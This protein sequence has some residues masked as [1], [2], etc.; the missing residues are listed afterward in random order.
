MNNIFV[1][2]KLIYL[3]TFFFSKW[4]KKYKD[5]CC[6]DK[7]RKIRDKWNPLI[8]SWILKCSF[9][10]MWVE[11]IIDILQKEK[12]CQKSKVLPEVLR[13]YK[14]WWDYFSS[15]W[16]GMIYILLCTWYLRWYGLQFKKNTTKKSQHW[17]SMPEIIPD[18]VSFLI[19]SSV[20]WLS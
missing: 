10:S 17:L 7:G 3:H 14:N 20:P 15:K 18:S 19:N 6:K 2:E 4:I 11:I 13:P 12:Q 8:T 9:W 1:P 16:K 5:V